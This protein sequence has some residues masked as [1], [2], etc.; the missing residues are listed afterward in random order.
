MDNFSFF[1]CQVYFF[2]RNKS[3]FW[4]FIEGN[5]WIIFFFLGSLFTIYLILPISIPLWEKIRPLQEI[6]FSWRL[7][8]VGIFT[9][10][11]LFSFMLAKIKSKYVYLIIFIGVSFLTV[12]GTRNFMLP[13]P[14]SV[15]DLYKYDDFEKLHQHRYSTTTLGDD[16]ISPNA[17]KACWFSTPVISTNNNEDLSSRIVERDNTFGSVKFLIDKNKIKGNKIIIGLGY[18]SDIHTVSLNGK[19]TD[20]TDCGGLVCFNTDKTRNGENLV[21]WKVGQSRIEKIFNYLA[22]TFFLIWLIILIIYLTG[23]NKNRKKLI[24][25]LLAITVFTLYIF[26]RSYNLPGRLGFGWDQERDAVTVSNILAGKLTLLGPRVQGPSGFFLPPYFFYILTPFYLL[27]GLNPIATNVFIIFWS[28]LFAWNPVVVP[29]LF[30]SLIYLI[31]LYLKKIKAKYIFLAGIIFGMGLSSHL[32][33]LFIAP[34]FAPLLIDIFK[35]KKYKHFILL[36]LGSVIPFVPILFF[37]LRHNFLNLNLIA[38]FT[39]SVGEGV[40]RVL[41]VWE[42]VSSFMV[43]G[44]PSVL[45]AITIYLF[46]SVGLFV[47][48]TR[49][50][51]I[52]QR[53][54]LFGLGSVWVASLPLFYI[55]IKSPSEYY[56]NYLLVPF[57]VLISILLKNLKRFGLFALILI[58]LYFGVCSLPLLRDVSLSLREK[59][60]AVGLLKE[61]TK[62]SSP[63]NISFDVPFNEDTGFRY[64][65]KFHKVGHSGSANDPLIEFVIPRQKRVTTFSF[66]QLGIYVPPVWLKNNWPEKSK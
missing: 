27:T 54:V 63:F 36:I 33:F 29:L 57:L 21:S 56:F 30:I 58:M 17:V 19:S 66:G 43:G 12:I 45:L 61:I 60:R 5:V 59:D 18:F 9:T 11:S 7:L 46:V 23:I 22:L 14:I 20:Y 51:D 48:A 4:D 64:L 53:R 1:V 41:M 38:G 47:T 35:C 37:D 39:K 32:Q 55:L 50:K 3:K 52:V 8:G 49:I 10:S 2:I 16:V 15:E 26:F 13:Q 42:R 44:S 6:Q 40:G 31:Y 62:N 65:L 34:M 25:F 28:T 24:S